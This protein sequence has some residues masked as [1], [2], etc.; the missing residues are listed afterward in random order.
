M[1][2]AA[3]AAVPTEME[4]QRRPEPVEERPQGETYQPLQPNLAKRPMENQRE[5]PRLHVGIVPG[6]GTQLHYSA[7]VRL[8][9]DSGLFENLLPFVY[10]SPVLFSQAVEK[11]EWNDLK[12]LV[13]KNIQDIKGKRVQMLNPQEDSEETED[14]GYLALQMGI[15]HL[16]EGH[17]RAL[18]SLPCNEERIRQQ[19]PDFKTQ[20]IAVAEIFSGTP[21]RMLLARSMRF[22][23]LT[24]AGR[25]DLAEY[26]SAQRVEQRLRALYA[27]LQSDFSITTPRIAVL[28]TDTQIHSDQQTELDKKVLTP[29]INN[30]FEKGMPVFGPYSAQDF[31]NKSGAQ[32]F[33]AVLCMYKEQMELVFVHCPKEDCCYHTASLPVVHVEPVFGGND[34]ESAFRSVYRALC[35]AADID[36]ARQQYRK[37]TENPLGYHAVSYRRDGHEDN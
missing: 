12:V 2:S 20:A 19:H 29:V 24:T 28:G 26:L 27:V 30:L 25:N 23:F 13:H 18:V 4:A 37:L 33:D 9:S 5:S 1:K 21:F 14:N 34:V 17:L 36:A 7:L 8:F 11:S 22:S 6:E 32:S 15:Q 10:G 16:A 31:F 3:Q 35:M